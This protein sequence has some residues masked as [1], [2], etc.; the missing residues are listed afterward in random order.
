[1]TYDQKQTV[2]E[3]KRKELIQII[4]MEGCLVHNAIDFA[5]EEYILGLPCDEY[6]YFDFKEH[7]EKRYLKYSFDTSEWKFGNSMIEVLLHLFDKQL[8]KVYMEI[9]TYVYKYFELLE[10]EDNEEYIPLD[11][12]ESLSDFIEY[13]HYKMEVTDTVV[14]N[15]WNIIPKKR[16]TKNK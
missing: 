12:F 14:D 2:I 7:F 8:S 16:I 5:I 11:Q 9:K 15:D 10:K 1:M 6:S 4:E 13:Y 3:I